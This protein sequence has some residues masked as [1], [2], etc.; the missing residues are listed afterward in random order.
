VFRA[1]AGPGNVIPPSRAVVIR[2]LPNGQQLMI[3]VDL[4]KARHD[5]RE[6]IIIQ[7][8]DFVMMHYKPGEIAGN[9][10]L[11]F[12]QFTGIFTLGD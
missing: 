6:R 5:V 9:V 4:S 11:N 2:K 7:P 3:R 1:G 8:G 12:F 10:A